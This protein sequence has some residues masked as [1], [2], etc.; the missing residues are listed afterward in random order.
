LVD[1]LHPEVE[2]Y[3]AEGHP[4]AGQGPW[5]GPK[6]VVQH[7]VNPINNDWEGF[8]TQVDE[9]IGVGSRVIVVGRYR[10]RHRMTGRDID[11]QVCTLY[12]VIDGLITRWQQF[13]DTAQLQWACS[14]DA[15]HDPDVAS[16]HLAAGND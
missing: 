1:L 10:G 8:V 7:V 13:T 15:G 11:A 6:E 3:Q 12:T 9:V 4:Y 14:E 16:D 2:W 5:R